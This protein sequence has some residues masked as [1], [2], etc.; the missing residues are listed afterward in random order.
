MGGCSASN[1]PGAQQGRCRAA[2]AD[3]NDAAIHQALT[4]KLAQL[5]KREERLID[6]AESGLP[7]DKIRGRI[8]SLRSERARLNGEL[9]QTGEEL[10]T[11]A[12]RL[13][14]AVALLQDVPQLY[15]TAVDPV[16]GLTN[17]CPASPGST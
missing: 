14:A 8:N 11:G 17:A 5:D 3:G 2:P 16:R 10:A 1:P 7:Q 12:E 15:E 9:A 13:L 4:K 6:L